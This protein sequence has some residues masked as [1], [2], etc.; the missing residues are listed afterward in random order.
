MAKVIN[1]PKKYTELTDDDL[2]VTLNR[3]PADIPSTPELREELERLIRTCHHTADC[4]GFR[5][6]A[7]KISP[8]RAGAV[9]LGAKAMRLDREIYK[10]EQ[11]E[12][13]AQSS[14][15]FLIGDYI[16]EYARY[17]SETANSAP[18]RMEY[19]WIAETL[20]H[21]KLTLLTECISGAIFSACKHPLPVT[22]KQMR[23]RLRADCV[24]GIEKVFAQCGASLRAN[25]LVTVTKALAPF[26]PLGSRPCEDQREDGAAHC[27]DKRVAFACTEPRIFV[28]TRRFFR[29]GIVI[30]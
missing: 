22:V 14:W 5:E 3:L 27:Q 8:K 6:E 24:R 19:E 15:L 10:M 26:F 20:P 17:R 9:S 13:D 23:M 21:I 29:I 2:L 11:S 7:N 4:N 30:F 28:P 12:N 25:Q 1:S 16:E 18:E